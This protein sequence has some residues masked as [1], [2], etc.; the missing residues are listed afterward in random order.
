MT[1][2]APGGL[3]R[4]STGWGIRWREGSKRHRQA[5]FPTQREARRWFNAHVAPRLRSGALRQTLGAAQRWGYISVNPAVQAGRNPQPRQ[6]ELHPFAGMAEVDKL[7]AELGSVYGP[8]VVFAAETGLRT[9][10]WVA[11]ERRDVDRPGRA[12]TVQRR[13]AA[14]TLTPYPKTERSRR[15][16]PLSVR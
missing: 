13:Y 4:T 6:D 7:A 3:Y 9:N 2:E 12:C 16:V 10:E 8:M 14:G 5:G 1:P 11:L 15:R